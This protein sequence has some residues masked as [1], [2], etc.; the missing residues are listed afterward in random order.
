MSD[1][2]AACPFCT[3]DPDRVFYADS[4]VMGIWDG[5]PVSPGHALLVPRRH[6]ASWFEAT[7]AEKAAL[8][9]AVEQAKVAIELSKNADGYNIG[10]NVGKA[11]GKTIFHL[12]VHLLPRCSGDVTDR[13]G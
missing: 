5:F 11:A 8:F 7:P 12:H 3:P 6:V 13:R 10:I 1:G 4:L 9:A 2:A